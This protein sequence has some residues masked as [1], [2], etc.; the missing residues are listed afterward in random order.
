MAISFELNAEVRSEQGKGASRRLRREGKVPGIIYG[1]HAEPQAIT[2]DQNEL[3]RNLKNEAFYSH[4]LTI[5]LG[6]EK[7]QAILRDIQRHP[8]KQLVSHVDLLRV[9]AG[10]AIRVHV[11]LHFVNQE[12]AVGV[13]QQGG[14]VSHNLI[15]VEIE[16][17]PKDLPEFIEVDVQNLEL[18]ESLHMSDMTLPEGVSLVELAH[19][20]HDTTVVTIHAPRVTREEEPEE[21][22]A[23]AGEEAAAK[24]EAGEADS[25]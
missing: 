6:K 11:P 20:G 21:G 10:E 9:S 24:P 14:V 3:G 8:Y 7:Q 22:E 5:N 1:G 23:E 18:G 16:C 15:E 13:K 25:E 12:T 19:G 2:L 17:L 4:I